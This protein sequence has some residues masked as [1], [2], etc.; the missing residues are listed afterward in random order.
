MVHGLR[1][2]GGKASYRNR[3]V[4]T[5]QHLKDKARGDTVYLFGEMQT[6]NPDVI[7]DQRI[8]GE[9]GRMMGRLQT[10]V[11]FHAG[12][13]LALEETD[14]PYQLTT[15]DLGRYLLHSTFI[16]YYY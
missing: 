5:E 16:R 2:K 11:V 1:L 4:R 12:R 13:L 14:Q 3:Y 9:D 7:N 10:S 15:P 8:Y 6:G